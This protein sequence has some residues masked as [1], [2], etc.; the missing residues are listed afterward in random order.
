M[1][2]VL[3]WILATIGGY[4][5]GYCIAAYRASKAQSK[6]LTEFHKRNLEISQKNYDN[7]RESINEREKNK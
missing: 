2:E 5:L 4:S 7:L 3:S 6:F 1:I